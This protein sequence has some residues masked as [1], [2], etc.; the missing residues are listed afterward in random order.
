MITIFKKTNPKTSEV[1]NTFWKFAI[2]R[3]NIFFNR[4]NGKQVWTQ[5]DI[6]LKYK[7]TNAYR[8]SD[9]TSQYLIRN[10]IYNYSQEPKEILFRILL[11]K[12]FNKIETWEILLQKL[13]IISY[14]EFNFS[15]YDKILTEL[16]DSEKPIYSGAYIMASGRS[17]FGFHKKHR[18]HLKLIESM[19]NDDLAEKVTHVKSLKELFLILKN[20]PTIGNF[21]AYQYSIDINYSILT[22]FDE[23]SFVIPGPG[24]KDGIKK[25]FKDLGGYNEVDIIK[26]MT[27]NQQNEFNKFEG[28]FKNLWGRDLQ[29]IDCQNILCEVDK[30]SRIAH[31]EIIGLSGRS[32][33]KQKFKPRTQKI[34]Y[35]YPP[36]WNINDKIIQ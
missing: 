12:T 25:C 11:F 16:L 1:Y 33:I 36:K 9:R 4:K 18:N 23:M 13:N 20:Y 14:R 6:F 15:E 21:L 28:I 10:V 24:A 8:A 29:L 30:Y 34:D 3:Q 17:K 35:W 31:P 22:N 2:E 26:W 5:D 32:R 27:M 7:F 19:I